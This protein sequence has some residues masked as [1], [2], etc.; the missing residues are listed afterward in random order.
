MGF[1]ANTVPAG[2]QNIVGRLAQ[3]NF[4]LSYN[5]VFIYCRITKG[6]V[7][8][9]TGHSLHDLVMTKTYYVN[10]IVHC[11]VKTNIM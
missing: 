11:F 3:C 8:S 5:M 9:N 6:G 1:F 7:L 4:C 2:G 10:S